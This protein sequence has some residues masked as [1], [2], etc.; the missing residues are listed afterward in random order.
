MDFLINK[1]SLLL[2]A[3][4]PVAVETTGWGKT[5][6]TGMAVEGGAWVVTKYVLELPEAPVP[7]T[8]RELVTAKRVESVKVK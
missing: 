4:G 7:P 3:E 2:K 1:Y 5:F 8:D 6:A